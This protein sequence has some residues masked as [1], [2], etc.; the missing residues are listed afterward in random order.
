[1]PL[2]LTTSPPGLQLLYGG[3]P[4]NTPF[5]TNAVVGGTRTVEA[6]ATQSGGTFSKWSDGGA[7]QHNIVIGTAAINLTATYT[8]IASTVNVSSLAT[9]G[10]PVNGW[11]P[12]ERD[13][14]NGEQGASDGRTLQI[15]TTTYTTGLGVHAASDLRFTVPAGC[16]TFTANIGVDSEVGAHG[17]VSFEVWNGTTTRLYQSAVLPGGNAATSISVPITGVA[18]LRLVVTNGGDNIDWDHADWAN[19]KLACS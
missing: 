18:T 13:R 7:I 4:V 8:G 11:G 17:T 5:T 10:T 1:M 9:T 6:I 3:V 15:G 19:A 12:F 14:S 2:T 16:T